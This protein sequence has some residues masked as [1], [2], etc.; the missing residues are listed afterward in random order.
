V[1]FGGLLVVMTRVAE[2]VSRPHGARVVGATDAEGGLVFSMIVVGTDGSET[3]QVA[4][5]RALD[6]GRQYGATVHVVHA[7]KASP[8]GMPVDQIGE[9]IIVRGDSA[10]SRELGD[11]TTAL[12]E[13]AIGDATGVKTE[14]HAVRGSAADALIEVAERISADLIVVGSKGM[15]GGRRLIGSIPNSVAHRAPCDVL[16]VKS[17]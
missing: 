2:V 4:V 1:A 8:S 14:T 5:G 12:L 16:I 11:A 15:Q 17:V 7:L 6:L 10:M 3:A 9:T 13:R